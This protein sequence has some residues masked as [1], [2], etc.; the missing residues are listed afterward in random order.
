MQ[1]DNKGAY[2]E[3]KVEKSDEGLD[4]I[5]QTGLIYGSRT[6]G[7]YWVKY[8]SSYILHAILPGSEFFLLHQQKKAIIVMANC[9][10]FRY[11]LLPLIITAFYY[12]NYYTISQIVNLNSFLKII[13]NLIASLIALFIVFNEAGVYYDF[14][15]LLLRQFDGY[16]VTSGEFNTVYICIGSICLEY[17]FYTWLLSNKTPA[18]WVTQCR[19]IEDQKR[20][21]VLIIK[22]Y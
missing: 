18:N 19:K 12:M 8:L 17:N 9:F 11:L 7:M 10:F 2:G 3:L 21:K 16:P 1:S 14:Y 15:H 20:K 4:Y 5:S 22:F 13:L 6:S